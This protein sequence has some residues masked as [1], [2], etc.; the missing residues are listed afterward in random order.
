VFAQQLRQL[1]T[2]WTAADRAKEPIPV[3]WEIQTL[4][5]IVA[6]ILLAWLRFL[7]A[8]WLKT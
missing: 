7:A 6:G 4:S 3:S 2:W 1:A 5:V 8:T